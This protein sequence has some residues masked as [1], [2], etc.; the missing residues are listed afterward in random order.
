M[1][2]F[3]DGIFRVLKVISDSDPAGVHC[4]EKSYIDKRGW[5]FE[6]NKV[7]FFITTFAPFYPETHPRYSFGAKDC[8]IL[9]QPELSF[10]FHDLPPDSPETNWD[11]PKT[12]RDK[13]RVAFKE[14]G[15]SYYI[16]ESIFSPMVHEILR[17][18]S[19]SASYYEWWRNGKKDQ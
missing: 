9:L 4:I 5:V 11:T 15:R 16:P 14:A 2:D 18:I 17:P 1:Q 6:F 12:V 19:D 13:I 7:T 3:G 8:Y 10:A